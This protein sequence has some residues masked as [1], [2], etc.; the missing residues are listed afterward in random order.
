MA[1][2]GSTVIS[3]LSVTIDF[4]MVNN[5]AAGTTHDEINKA[6]GYKEGAV[7]GLNTYNGYYDICF[8]NTMFL[9]AVIPIYGGP[10]HYIITFTLPS[11]Q[12]YQ[13]EF[14]V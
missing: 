7:E 11:G 13:G 3:P 6:L 5:G 2:R 8:I 12:Q 4:G 1:K 9:S 14:D 10:G